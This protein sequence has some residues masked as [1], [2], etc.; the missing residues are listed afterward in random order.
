MS[1]EAATWAFPRARAFAN[2]LRRRLTPLL[3][4]KY[5][6]LHLGAGPC[7][8]PGWANLDM[9]GRKN[10][11]WDLTNPLP[12]KRGSVTHVY[13]EHFVEHI[14]RSDCLKLLHNCRESMAPG[15]VLRISTPDLKLFAESYLRGEA[16]PDWGEENPCRAFNEVMRNW[17]HTFLYDEEELTSLLHEAGF[18]RVKRVE[19][20]VSEHPELHNMER[21]GSQLDLI[22]EARP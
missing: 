19:H 7:H 4:K 14:P 1:T 8:I 2:L 9:W 22:M 18:S 20:R 13:S 6:K 5:N 12:V 15:G 17:G 16:P 11:I 21:R 3:L 10:L